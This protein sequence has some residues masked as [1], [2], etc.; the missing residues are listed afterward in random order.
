MFM[1]R[2]ITNYIKLGIFVI[3]GLSFLIFLL[4][5]IGKNQNLFGK[6]FILKARF[7][8]I[9]GLMPGNNIRYAGIDAG[10]V[11]SIDVINDSTIEVTLMVKTKMKSYIHKNAIVSIT[12]DGL[13]GNKLIN[14]QSAKQPAPLV[15]EG[16]ILY[17]TTVPGMDDIMK[18]LSSTA[19]DVTVIA[20]E[21]RQSVEKLNTSKALWTIL[22]D[23]TLPS[24]LRASLLKVRNASDNMN[25]MMA[26]L[27]SIVDDV[28]QGKGSVGV[29]LKDTSIA[30]NVKETIEKVKKAGIGADTL[31]QKINALVQ[32][33]DTT[34]NNGNGTVNALL[35]NKQMAESLFNDIRNIEKGTKSFNEI[36]NAIKSSFLFKGYFK[37]LEKQKTPDSL[38]NY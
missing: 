20:K 37:K 9:H 28:T 26:G 32:T 1:A 24:N 4:Y 29:L 36:M 17:S 30:G 33:I 31:M 19:Y 13:M 15:R 7:E 8:D 22:N 16:D 6:T 21:L 14:I 23:E 27:N 5:F 11:K 25:R 10:S 2:R 38:S 34:I 12:T 35:K 3:A 18:T